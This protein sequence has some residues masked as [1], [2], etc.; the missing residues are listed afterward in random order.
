MLCVNLLLNMTAVAAMP[1]QEINH[2]QIEGLK[3]SDPQ[4][5]LREL[6]FTE[7]EMWEDGFVQ[8]SERRLRNLGVLGDVTVFAPDEN[9]TVMIRVSD[10]WPVWLL[11]VASRKDGGASSAG[12]VLT[13][14]NLWGLNHQ[15]RMSGAIDTGKNFST[16]QGQSASFSYL[17]RR[18]NNSKVSLDMSTNRGKSSLDVFRAGIFESGYE[19][20]TNDV[21]VGMSYALGEVPGEGWGLRLG[22]SFSDAR[23]TLKQGPAQPD[24]INRKR[25]AFQVGSSYQWL[26]DHTTWLNG[27]AFD[28]NADVAV[29]WLGSNIGVIRQYVSWRQHVPVYEQNTIDVR[30][31]AGWMQGEIL[32]D[33]LFDLGDGQAMRGYYPG[34]LLGSAFIYGTLESRIILKPFDNVQWVSFIDAGHISRDGQ[35][36][37]GKSVVAGV[38]GGVRWVFRWLVNGTLR[39]DVAYGTALNKWRIHVGAGQAF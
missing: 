24:V 30:L 21:T 5:L 4:L 29:P 31:N 12:L 33:G 18:V 25:N 13:E 1:E 35:R 8:V 23:Y 20:N 9:G 3:Y 28:Y 11:P 39:V 36:A 16:N 19:R 17:W 22:G 38:G 27:M 10:R 7:G 6:P 15:L 14:Y 37:L 26:D 34:D 2:I 32:R